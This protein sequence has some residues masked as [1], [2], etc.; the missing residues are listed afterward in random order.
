MKGGR[1]AGSEKQS[2]TNEKT[3]GILGLRQRG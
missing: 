2:E 3:E 1:E